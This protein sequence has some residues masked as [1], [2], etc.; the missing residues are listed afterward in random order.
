MEATLLHS[1]GTKPYGHRVAQKRRRTSKRKSKSDGGA[2]VLAFV[3]LIVVALIWQVIRS[4]HGLVLWIP[5]AALGFWIWRR[6][7]RKKRAQ[8][9]LDEEAR[10][11]AAWHAEQARQRAAWEAELARQAA[12]L[13]AHHR[14]IARDLNDLLS[15]D[16][17][18][19]EHAVAAVLRG[20]GWTGV[21]VTKGSGD[22]GIDIVGIDLQGW[23]TVVQCK[24]YSYNPIGGPA[25]RNLE[26]ARAQ[27]GADRAMFVTTATFTKQAYE[28]AERTQIELVD[29]EGIV[30]L[31]RTIEG[32]DQVLPSAPVQQA[33]P[34]PPP[35]RAA[36][37]TGQPLPPPG[38]GIVPP[39]PDA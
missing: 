26:G 38:W 35:G 13:E 3:G 19:F 2:L 8:R 14:S 32:P 17:Y 22:R 20:V 18:Q 5:V 33:P 37:P 25:I 24:R 12:V 34:T 23:Q 30:M 36:P 31:A 21:E 4:T 39:T 7:D 6:L 1:V 29:G 16:P 28:A 15:L 10:Q 9:E 27:H 11:V